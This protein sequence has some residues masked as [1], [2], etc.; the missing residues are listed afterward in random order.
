[1]KNLK[2]KGVKTNDVEIIK[3]VRTNLTKRGNNTDG[4][5]TRFVE[6]FWSLDGRLLAENDWWKDKKNVEKI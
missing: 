1:V 6:Q 4:D 2:T 3:V 5:P